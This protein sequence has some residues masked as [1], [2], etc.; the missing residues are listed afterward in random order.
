MS[1]PAAAAAPSSS[2]F[3]VDE[4]YP[5]TATER[6]AAIHQRVKSLTG[7]DLSSDWED[8]RR[9]ILWAGGLKD[10]PD[11]RPG[12]GY[13]GHSFNDYNHTALCAMRGEEADNRNEG[14][15]DGIAYSNRL[16]PGIQIASLPELGPGGSWSTCMQGCHRDPP[17]DVAHLQFRARVAFQ[18]VWCP[19][20]FSR[21]VLVDDDGALLNTGCPKGRLPFKGDREMNF[22]LVGKSKYAKEALRVGEAGL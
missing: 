15:V 10:L 16:G 17:S 1:S 14:K 19:P 8:V 21:F 3:P 11:A 2:G 22:R 18:L 4:L 5:G 12:Q 20:D 9:K 13:T 7:A 6:V